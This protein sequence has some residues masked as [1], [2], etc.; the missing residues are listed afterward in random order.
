MAIHINEVFPVLDAILEQQRAISDR[1][2]KLVETF[3]KEPEPIEPTL[4][5]M[6]K[7]LDE[8][9]SEMKE[10]LSPTSNLDGSS[11]NPNGS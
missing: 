8:G 9:M 11:G 5:L 3:K 2:R 1:L 4:R 10:T 6:L 7:P